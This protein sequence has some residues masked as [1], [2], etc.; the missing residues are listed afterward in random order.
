MYNV[1]LSFPLGRKPAGHSPVT[2]GSA[3]KPTSGL[4]H[5]GGGARSGATE[6]QLEQH[7]SEVR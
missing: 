7:K 2:S 3:R 1:L 6:A 5:G 4:S